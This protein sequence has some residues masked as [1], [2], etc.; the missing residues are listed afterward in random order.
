MFFNDKAK[1]ILKCSWARL[2]GK[3]E[4]ARRVVEKDK[5]GITP[6][7]NVAL[8][9]WRHCSSSSFQKICFNLIINVNGSLRK[10]LLN[11]SDLG[12]PFAA[13]FRI[14]ENDANKKQTVSWFYY[15][16]VIQLCLTL[17]DPVDCSLPGSSVR[18][19]IQARI[20]EWIA[21]SFSMVLL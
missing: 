5:L 1:N 18:G 21:I 20:L 15:C 4:G 16:S 13:L 14:T 11:L 17:C 8:P 3:G 10:S 2:W 7:P 12:H 9:S 19:I 6:A